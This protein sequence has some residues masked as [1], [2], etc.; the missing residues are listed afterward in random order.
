[1]HSLDINYFARFYT[2]QCNAL[3]WLSM[4]SDGVLGLFFIYKSHTGQLRLHFSLLYS[5]GHIW[6]GCAGIV[7]LFFIELIKSAHVWHYQDLNTGCDLHRVHV[8]QA[9]VCLQMKTMKTMKQWKQFCFCVLKHST[10]RLTHVVCNHHIHSKL[11][12][13]HLSMEVNSCHHLCVWQS[14]LLFE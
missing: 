5:W 7:F 9:V 4:K 11:N 1:M 2:P 8:Y 12:E 3:I 13:T 10:G 14:N 6:K